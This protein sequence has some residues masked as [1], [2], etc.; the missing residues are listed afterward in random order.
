MDVT[1]SF[2]GLLSS[3]FSA[4]SDSTLSCKSF[5]R[6]A[7]QSAKT[8]SSTLDF[9]LAQPSVSFCMCVN[10]LESITI[11]SLYYA[12]TSEPNADEEAIEK[13][14]IWKFATS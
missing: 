5:F 6:A 11:V 10:V 3:Y 4:M 14:V 2:F 13:H 12:K 7:F 1:S 8:G 9:L